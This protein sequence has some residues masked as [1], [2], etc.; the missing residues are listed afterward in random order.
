MLNKLK[1]TLKHTAIYSLGN[2]SAKIVGFLLLPLYLEYLTTEEYGIL[3][4]LEVT[5]QILFGIFSMSI[6]TA[7]LR[8]CSDD[9]DVLNHKRI[10]FSSLITTLGLIAVL[11][12]CFLPF[13]NFLS[14]ALFSSEKFSLY[15]ILMVVS[16]SFNVLNTIPLSLIRL[17]EKPAFFTVITSLRF[18]LVLLL[19]VFFIVE[20]N[21]GVEGILISQIIGNIVLFAVCLPLLFRNMIPKTEM[22]VIKEMLKYGGPLV[23]STISGTLLSFGDRYILNAFLS[24][25][26]VGIYSLGYKIASVIKIFLLQS[27]Q[28]GFLP[29]A[30]KNLNTKGS[31]RFFSKVHTYFV[32]IMLILSLVLSLYAQEVILMMSD[33]TEYFEAYKIVP[34][35]SLAFVFTG[36]R[37]VYAL[38]FHFTKKTKYNA[39]IVGVGAALNIGLNIIFIPIFGYIGSAI[40]MV[41]AVGLMTLLSFIYSQKQYY[42][43]YEQ[44]KTVLQILT[45]IGLYLVSLLFNEIQMFNRLILKTLLLISFPIILYFLNFYE[46]I[47]LQRIKEF[48]QKVR[49]KI[50]V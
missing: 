36:M 26:S 23:V 31:D 14:S 41:I 34:I 25:S 8:W 40:S 43:S 30:F 29:I 7:M 39:Y 12:I 20:L 13:S 42:I 33:K 38:G 15:I 24:L 45:A 18:T 27:F 9:K 22:T 2:L 44:K 4:I 49:D 16:A 46:E 1:K 48:F 5:T 35:I 19:N 10:V 32:F 28:L 3:A 21:Y 37:Y 47:E 6:S 11:N 17:L 50:N